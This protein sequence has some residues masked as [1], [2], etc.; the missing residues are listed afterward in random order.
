[1]RKAKEIEN[2]SNFFYTFNVIFVVFF[3][4]GLDFLDRYK[5]VLY[6]MKKLTKNNKK[7]FFCNGK[8]FKKNLTNFY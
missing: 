4:L 8:K 1:M 5:N 3:A 6:L 7:I 2:E